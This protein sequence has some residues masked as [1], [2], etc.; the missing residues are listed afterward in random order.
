MLAFDI[1][2]VFI[3]RFSLSIY[4]NILLR[5]KFI[6]I[7]QLLVQDVV[8]FVVVI[9]FIVIVV[10]VVVDVVVIIVVVVV[11]VVVVVII[12]VVVVI[13]IKLTFFLTDP[14]CVTT[15]F[16]FIHFH[17]CPFGSSYLKKTITASAY[18]PVCLIFCIKNRL[19]MALVDHVNGL[20][21]AR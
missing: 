18:Y 14:L 17:Q 8:I 4:K 11:V 6:F 5:D 15:L 16:E 7:D 19:K 13:V 2:L 10:V 21:N 1:L 9:V 3:I 20:F 12:I